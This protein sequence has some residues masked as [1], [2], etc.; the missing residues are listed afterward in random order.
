MMQELDL[1]GSWQVSGGPALAIEATVPGCIHTDLLAA[2]VIQDPFFREN[3]NDVQWVGETRWTYRRSFA[4]PAALLRHDRV[5]LRCEGLDTLASIAINGG[6]VGR[7]DNMYRCFEFDVKEL[8]RAGADNTIEI[9]FDSPLPLMRER[10]GER[11]MASWHE[12]DGRSWVRKAP[13]NFGW[14]WGPKLVTCG[15]WR[16]IGLCA[17]SSARLTDVA[18]EQDHRRRRVVGLRVDVEVEKTRR[19][20][21]LTLALTVSLGRKTVA[22]QSTEVRGKQGRAELSIKEPRLWWPNGLGAQ[23]LYRLRVELRD[24]EGHVLDRRDQRL[25][26]RTLRLRREQDRWGETFEFVAN[27]VAFFAKG[28]N[29]IP[30]DVFVT[31]LSRADYARLLEASVAA[32]MNMLRVWGGGIYEDDAFYELCDE[33]G[34]CVW[35][36]FMFSCAAYPSFDDAFVENVRAEA[37]DNVRRLRHH[38]SLALWCGNNELEQGMAAETWT[39]DTMSWQDYSK[40]FDEL[41]PEVVRKLDPQR[42]YWPGSPHSPCGERTDW[43]NPACGDAHLWEVWHGRK[44]FEWYL[45]SEHRFCSEFG[46][47]SFPEPR[48]VNTFTRE[49]DR[50][51]TSPVMEHHQRSPI[52]NAVIMTYLLDWFRA[53][54]DFEATLRLSQILQGLGMKIA[55]EHWR[56]NMPRSMGALYWQLNDCWPVASWASIDS[57]G[58]WKALHHL[59]RGFYAPLLVS[60][61]EKAK[62]GSVEVHVT[63]DLLARVDGIVSFRL[64]D[65]VGRCL[66]EGRK[67]IS[68]APRQSRCVQTLPLSRYLESHGQRDLMLWLE[69]EVGHEVASSNLVSFSKPKQLDLCDPKISVRVAKDVASGGFRLHLK[70]R[71]PALWVW[72]EL[73]GGDASF[74]DNYFHLRPGRG[75]EI[76]LVTAEPRTLKVVREQLVVRSLVDTY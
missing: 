18:I 6:A 7:T 26:L 69:L 2:G 35:Q 40:L 32:N 8:L 13:C 51:I 67:T 62:P 37:R 12:R 24:A 36:D 57:L 4:V 16:K 55:V 49:G 71:R 14:D 64:T 27:G 9:S 60:A 22:Q 33:L 28:A 48:T 34:L 50:N 43:N 59:A 41:L 58:R 1:G 54:R 31:R 29:W 53:P 74:S 21:G 66:D 30:A 20:K 25:G 3:E 17:F 10:Q 19:R 61:V 72:L 73:A 38:P 42:D 56:R 70:A 5:L 68:I 44:P 76:T 46:F 15:I 63:S 52:G 45:G 75:V 23:P 47:Q 11:P 65:V 39:N